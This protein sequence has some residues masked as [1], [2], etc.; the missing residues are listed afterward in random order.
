MLQIL[1][2]TRSEP[3]ATRKTVFR[4]LLMQLHPDKN[5]DRPEEATYAF[6]QLMAK[7]ASYFDGTL[8]NHVGVIFPC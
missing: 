4:N 6:Q 7:R 5:I 8:D 1:E 2:Q 3:F